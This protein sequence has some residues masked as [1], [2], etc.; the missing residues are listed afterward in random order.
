MQRKL[1]NLFNAGNLLMMVV[2]MGYIEL[3]TTSLTPAYFECHVVLSAWY[4]IRITYYIAAD[5]I[6]IEYNKYIH[7]CI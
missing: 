3:S 5:V 2:V 1:K 6:L 7:N 4:I